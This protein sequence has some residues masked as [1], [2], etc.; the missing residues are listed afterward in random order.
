LSGENGNLPD[1]QIAGKPNALFLRTTD[2]GQRSTKKSKSPKIPLFPSQK[3]FI[4]YAVLQGNPAHIPL[5]L[6]IALA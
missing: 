4:I 5:D 6:P 3:L 2:N 1:K